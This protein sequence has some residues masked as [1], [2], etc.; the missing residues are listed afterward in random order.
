MYMKYSTSLQLV[1]Y[2]LIWKLVNYNLQ[3]KKIA[4]DKVAVSSCS[5]RY[6]SLSTSIEIEFIQ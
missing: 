6:K 5:R 3:Q 1:D 2:H 4:P